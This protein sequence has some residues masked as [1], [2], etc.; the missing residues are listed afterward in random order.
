M[1]NHAGRNL[2]ATA[3]DAHLH[4]ERVAP[5]GGKRITYARFGSL[6]TGTFVVLDGVPCLLW[7]GK[8]FAW[9]HTGYTLLRRVLPDDTR[10]GVLTPMSIVALFRAGFQ[11]Q[12]HLSAWN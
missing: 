6:P 5:D 3:I 12:V 1:A 2:P 10:V 8:L 11:P 7:R 9:S 4:T